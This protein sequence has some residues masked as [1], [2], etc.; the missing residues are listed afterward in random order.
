MNWDG[1]TIAYGVIAT[2]SVGA[3]AV[4]GTLGYFAWA[5]ERTLG[6]RLTRFVTPHL[7]ME[8]ASDLDE[9]FERLIAQVPG[10][11]RLLRDLAQFGTGQRPGRLLV[12]GLTFAAG[13][14]LAVGTWRNSTAFAAVGFAGALVGEY[15]MMTWRAS[16][17]WDRLRL[18]LPE[19]LHVVSSAL[20]AG[21]SLNQAL[22]HAAK[23]VL[24]PLQGELRRAVEDVELGKTL[25]EALSDLQRRAPLPE[26]NMIIASLLIQ[27]RSGGNL[28][29]LLNE[30]A[31]LLKED[32]RLRREMNVLT[33][34]A[35]AS[36]QLIGLLPI[37][38]FLYM[39]FFNPT[40]IE[41][42]L[43]TELGLTALGLGLVLELIGFFI[44][45]K[46]ATYSEYQE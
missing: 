19:A 23:E 31:E 5:R 21:A 3:V 42:L 1:L 10:G 26:F 27:Q 18:Q 4:A 29:Q 25:E 14:F 9:R 32:Q 35:R 17:R 38:L 33:S 37:G 6:D 36:A 44:V 20:S 46:I 11:F 39:F 7:E 45:Y 28:A 24:P 13:V 15:M 16:K 40:Y 43:T 2:A 41:P 12:Y 8:D 34:Q 30:T 22:I